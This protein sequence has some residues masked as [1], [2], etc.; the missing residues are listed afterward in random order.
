MCCRGSFCTLAGS[1]TR[2]PSRRSASASL[3][4]R[5]RPSRPEARFYVARSARSSCNRR[6]HRRSHATVARSTRS[7]GLLFRI[8]RVCRLYHSGN[9]DST[10]R[11]IRACDRKRKDCSTAELRR[12]L[13][14]GIRTPGSM[15]RLLRPGC[16][17]PNSLSSSMQDR[18]WGKDLDIVSLKSHAGYPAAYRGFANPNRSA[19][20]ASVPTKRI[21]RVAQLRSFDLRALRAKCLNTKRRPPA[22][23]GGRFLGACGNTVKRNRMAAMTIALPFPSIGARFECFRSHPQP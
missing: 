23:R 21:S 6:L 2:T 17:G 20:S 8:C 11:S 14:G 13:D 18:A 16:A 4:Q 7:A 15:I 22:R 5:L 19:R 3:T 9:Y 10:A 1:G 12:L